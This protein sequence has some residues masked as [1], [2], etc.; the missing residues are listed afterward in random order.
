MPSLQMLWLIFGYWLL[1]III[2]AWIGSVLSPQLGLVLFL[3]SLVLLS[4]R[5][6]PVGHSLVRPSSVIE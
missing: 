6:C 3:L 2:V 4:V 5:V 1:V